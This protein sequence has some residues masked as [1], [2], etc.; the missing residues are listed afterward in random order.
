MIAHVLISPFDSTFYS[1]IY[2]CEVVYRN[3]IKLFQDIIS[4]FKI[5]KSKFRIIYIYIY[6]YTRYL[7]NI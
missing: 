4:E 6:I 2:S 1:I 3:C 5:I 7:F